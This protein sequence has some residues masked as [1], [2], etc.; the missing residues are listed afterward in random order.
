MNTQNAKGKKIGRKVMASRA[1]LEVEKV[2]GSH[3]T[4]RRMPHL[5]SQLASGRGRLDGVQSAGGCKTPS[6]GV[7]P[8]SH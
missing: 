2:T 3:A 4:L 8:R 6:G 1:I 7:R 5:K